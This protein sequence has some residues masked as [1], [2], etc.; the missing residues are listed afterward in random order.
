MILK[1]QKLYSGEGV[2]RPNASLRRKIFTDLPAR[3]YLLQQREYAIRFKNPFKFISNKVGNWRAARATKRLEAGNVAAG[4]KAF[5]EGATRKERVAIQRR[6]VNDNG[7][8][9]LQSYK[10]PVNQYGRPSGV[11]KEVITNTN[12]AN[13]RHVKAEPNKS[14]LLSGIKDRWNQFRENLRFKRGVKNRT[15]EVERMRRDARQAELKKTWNEQARIQAQKAEKTDKTLGQG[16]R[17]F[18]NSIR[19][20]WNGFRQNLRNKIKTRQQVSAGNLS[21]AEQAEA[22]SPILGKKPRVGESIMRRAKSGLNRFTSGVKNMGGSIMSGA[23]SGLNRFKNSSG[24]VMKSLNPLQYIKG[25]DAWR[26]RKL[27]AGRRNTSKML[28]ENIEK[29]NKLGESSGKMGL[30]VDNTG[31]KFQ[32][33]RYDSTWTSNNR[34]VGETEK[35]LVEAGGN[36]NN[37]KAL[38]NQIEANKTYQQNN[39]NL[40]EKYGRKNQTSTT[41]PT[42]EEQ[43]IQN[44]NN[45][46][47]AEGVKNEYKDPLNPGNKSKSTEQPKDQGSQNKDQQQ[48]QQQNED[49]NKGG[50]WWKSVGKGALTAGKTTA[51]V[52]GGA[53]VGVLGASMLS[54]GSKKDRGAY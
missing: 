34:T 25:T 43:R 19:S 48:G 15:R 36:K 23:K 11:P 49:K 29:S 40:L 35:K 13:F 9:V 27:T 16:V 33:Q 18:G 14:S 26:Y 31:N 54:G 50:S 45:S 8:L 17:D 46:K 28:R 24:S 10:V 47:N 12:L 2:Y 6:V 41:T 37:I 32:S 53:G 38:E 7:N 22:A 44:L 5:E 21:A 42:V 30:R 52:L 39:A 1:R 20:R 3:P 4:K 51:G